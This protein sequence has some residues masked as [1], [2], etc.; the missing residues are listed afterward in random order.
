MSTD[1]SALHT[2]VSRV[3]ARAE[4][5][6]HRLARLYRGEVLEYR[7]LGEGAVDQDVAPLM[8]HKVRQMLASLSRGDPPSEE[9]LQ[10]NADAAA[11]RFH[12]GVPLP[13]VLR[14]YRL[15]GRTVWSEL[16]GCA[17][18]QDP[19]HL[20][21]LLELASAVM[22]HMD[23]LS[24]AVAQAYLEEQSGL[25]RS[26][27][28]LAREVLEAL[29]DGRMTRQGRGRLLDALEFQDL[30]V[31]GSAP[32]AVVAFRRRPAHTDSAGPRPALD[33]TREH[34]LADLPGTARRR[35]GLVGLREDE[36]VW[37]LE[38][39][40]DSGELRGAVTAA[41]EELPGYVAGLGSSGTGVEHVATSHRQAHAAAGIALSSPD[42]GPVLTHRDV[43][44]DLVISQGTDAAGLVEST[45][46]PLAAYDRDH[47][48][49]L[50]GTLEAYLAHRFHAAG[51]ATD[52][53]V[54][55]NTV[56]YRLERIGQVSGH[57]PMTPDGLLMLSLG[58]KALRL[59]PAGDA[60]TP[61]PPIDESSKTGPQV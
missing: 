36:I 33:V 38:C 41:L 27:S 58:I 4:Q 60:P 51:A 21:A 43:M 56:L 17:D 1:P 20:N 39:G 45:I 14:A 53:Q 44:L 52:L 35:R 31:G 22:E 59:R 37:I 8:V 54:R 10:L 3:D 24:S 30:D 25:R 32:H 61:G 18:L 7:S 55:P 23:V 49:D 46:G 16:Q 26:R 29:L 9:D 42:A 50:V 48:T 15:R 40:T 47:G 19:E 13:A 2:I 11:R 57:D 5:V 28:V 34:L 6:G 12:Q